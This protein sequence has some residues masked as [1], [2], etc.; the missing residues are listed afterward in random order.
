V[1]NQQITV[2]L[3][4]FLNRFLIKKNFS[5][6]KGLENENTINNARMRTAFKNFQ[7]I[8]LEQEFEK[9]MYLNR[10]RR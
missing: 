6:I 5:K 2:I 9:S 7:L 3:L 4:K 8:D 1:I 10:L